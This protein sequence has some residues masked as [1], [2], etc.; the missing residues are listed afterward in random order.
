MYETYKIH[1]LVVVLQS[2][3]VTCFTRIEMGRIEGGVGGAVGIR[4]I[5]AQVV[6]GSTYPSAFASVYHLCSD[7]QSLSLICVLF[8]NFSTLISAY[9]ILRSM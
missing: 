1:L 3:S 9:L 6:K 2:A 7:S 8:Y 5:C 4:A